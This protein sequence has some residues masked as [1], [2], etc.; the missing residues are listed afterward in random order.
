MQH[1]QGILTQK[2]MGQRQKWARC[3][4]WRGRWRDD[5]L[6]GNHLY[7]DLAGLCTLRTAVARLLL[8]SG[9]VAAGCSSHGGVHPTRASKAHCRP[10][11]NNVLLLPD[12]A[13]RYRRMCDGHSER[14]YGRTVLATRLQLR[15]QALPVSHWGAPVGRSFPHLSH[16]QYCQK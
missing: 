3:S 4:L 16:Q 11:G 8:F 12:T 6:C 5:R 1:G 10:R 14:S 7:P 2:A 15:Q 9:S 13:A